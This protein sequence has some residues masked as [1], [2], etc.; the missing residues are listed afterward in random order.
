MCAWGGL[1]TYYIIPTR[2]HIAIESTSLSLSLLFP[3]MSAP[4]PPGQLTRHPKHGNCTVYQ[5]S[6][7][8]V[9]AD[10]RVECYNVSRSSVELLKK[11][12]IMLPLCKTR[13]RTVP[14]E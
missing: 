6:S 13:T 4:Y 10:Y 1:G 3:F 12:N 11:L 2:T 7:V 14:L 5:R 9:C 8:L